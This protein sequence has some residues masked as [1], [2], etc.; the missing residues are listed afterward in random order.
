VFVAFFIFFTSHPPPPKPF[1]HK[2]TFNGTYYIHHPQILC[3]QRNPPPS[4]AYRH[5][6]HNNS[7]VGSKSYYP[8]PRPRNPQAHVLRCR[9]GGGLYCPSPS[10]P[11]FPL[12]KEQLERF[13]PSA[14]YGRSGHKPNYQRL[15]GGGAAHSRSCGLRGRKKCK[16]PCLHFFLKQAASCRPAAVPAQRG[17]LCPPSFS[18]YNKHSELRPTVSKVIHHSP[19]S[20]TAALIRKTRQSAERTGGIILW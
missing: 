18:S 16:R 12:S 4:T 13:T 19:I 20:V 17:V 6:S 5:I 7:T 9:H 14:P 1:A 3:G 15:K 11:G 10:P 2:A 8:H